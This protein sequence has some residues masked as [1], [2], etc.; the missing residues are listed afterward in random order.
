MAPV[1]ALLASIPSPSTGV[2]HV[3][4]LTIHMYGV[5]LL[6]A[7]AACIW[8]TGA[9]WVRWGG[10]WDLV[11]RVSI[12]G[13]IAGIIGARLYH[14]ITSW[15]RTGDPRALVRAVRGLGGRARDLGRRSPSACSPAR[16]SCGAPATASASSWTPSRR[17]SCSPR[18]SAAGATGGTRS[19][20]ASTRRCRGGSRSTARAP[21]NTYHPT[22]LYEFLW[23]VLGV[24]RAALDRPALQARRP[25]LFALYVAC[26]TA[27][28]M[29]EETLRIDPSAHFLGQRM[30]F[31]VVARRASSRAS[32]SSSG[33]SSCATPSRREPKPREAREAAR[34][35]QGPD[36]GRPARPR[37]VARLRLPP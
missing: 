12:W 14:E 4:P 36:D 37:P 28:R 19:S 27:F 7:I 21:A 1:S 33:G 23:D 16:G 24:A 5:M 26:Y 18:R 3:G 34:G 35:A 25:A 9:R 10:D 13:V 31:W 29:F 11:Y 30:N 17:A 2:Y 15:N 6:L 20:T 8:L 32:P 22:F